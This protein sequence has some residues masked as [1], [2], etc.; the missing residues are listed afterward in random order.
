MKTIEAIKGVCL[1][2]RVHSSSLFK[3]RGRQ[4]GFIAQRNLADALRGFEAISPRCG[5]IAFWAA[6]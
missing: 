4:A 1:S 2:L 5:T 6:D 3:R